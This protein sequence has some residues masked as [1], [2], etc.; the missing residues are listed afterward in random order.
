M[1]FAL[2]TNLDSSAPKDS[3]STPKAHDAMASMLHVYRFVHC[4]VIDSF[5][6][7]S[8][9]VVKLDLTQEI[10]VLYIKL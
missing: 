9:K 6:V 5:C 4:V 8:L 7:K 10:E 1:S 3:A 2:L